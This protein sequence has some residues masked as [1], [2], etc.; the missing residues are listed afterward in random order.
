MGKLYKAKMRNNITDG[1]YGISCLSEFRGKI[2]YLMED[3]GSYNNTREGRSKYKGRKPC[4]NLHD[5]YFWNDSCFE[6]VMEVE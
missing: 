4:D 1:F 2:I 5:V 6:W 3:N